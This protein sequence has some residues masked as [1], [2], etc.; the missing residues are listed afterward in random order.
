MVDMENIAGRV[1][2]LPATDRDALHTRAHDMPK[3]NC[4]GRVLGRTGL[5]LVAPLTSAERGLTSCKKA[6]GLF[7][8]MYAQCWE[9]GNDDACQALLD[10]AEQ[11]QVLARVFY[12][13]FK[14]YTGIIDWDTIDT[15][16]Q[17]LGSHPK[18]REPTSLRVK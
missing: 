17:M 14:S 18:S 15:G 7:E 4:K 3:T 16:V 5:H 10:V 12:E 2:D 11:L 6:P 1:H 9:T 8:A 13:S